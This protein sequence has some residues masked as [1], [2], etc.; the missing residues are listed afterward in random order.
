MTR[1]LS[2]AIAVAALLLA[3]VP[4]GA[5]AFGPLSSFGSFGTGAGQFKGVFG[6]AI[7]PD[8]TTYVS[9]FNADRV[10]AFGAGG[11]FLFS[12]GRE[13]SPSGA[14]IC[15]AATGCGPGVKGDAAG[16]MSGPEGVAIGPEGNVF[17]ADSGNERIDVFTP[18]GAFLRAFGKEVN[19]DPAAASPDVC[20]A[21]GCKPGLSSGAAGAMRE[22]EGIGFDGSGQLYV[23]DRANNRVDVF[24][25][26]GAFVRAFGG[27][28]NQEPS[29]AP[30][31]VC[32][33]A[34][35]CRAGRAGG[36]PDEITLPLDVEAAPTGEIVISSDNQKRID[37]FTPG[38]EFLRAFGKEVNPDLTASN[39]DVCTTASGCLAGQSGVAPGGFEAPEGIAVDGAGN[40]YVA[41]SG[42]GRVDRFSLTGGFTSAFGEGVIDG[43]EAFQVCTLVC[44]HGL[45]NPTPA[46]LAQPSVVALDCRGAVYVSSQG[47][48]GQ[49][50][51]KFGHV[52]RFGEAGTPPPPCTATRGPS[53]PRPSSAFRF[54][55]LVL[56]RMKGT[57]TLA[58]LVPGPGGLVVTG[59]GL[60]SVKRTAHAAGPVTL[61]IVPVA[62]AKRTLAAHGTVK[63][64]VRVTFTPTGGDAATQAKALRLKRTAR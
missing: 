58:V 12:V 14:G 33:A 41:D 32:T 50:G 42:A 11:A 28:V 18:G 4:A 30:P 37:V 26:A 56:N 36:D 52:E 2:C 24:S 40:V 64:R 20:T 62:K 49:G 22:P 1:R 59:K 53:P 29:P 60:K 45:E 17:V 55:K 21:S 57:A 23:A 8:G 63:L 38:G 39:R 31:G 47:E 61:P 51:E 34:T 54:G 43:G 3:V 5:S 25:A 13:V 9:E 27:A 10:D 44:G 48:N 6:I 7:A 15:T 19:P 16:A 35:G 46:G